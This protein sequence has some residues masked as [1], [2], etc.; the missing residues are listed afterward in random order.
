MKK[1]SL[2]WLCWLLCPA[3]ALTFHYGPGQVWLARDR[4]GEKISLANTRSVS[5]VEKQEL[6]YQSQL[7]V[8]EARKQ[9]FIEGV[10][11]QSQP[12]H[13]LAIAVSDAES[14][15]EM[16]YQ[17]AAEEWS[18]VTLAYSQASKLLIES[19]GSRLGD[20]ELV[21]FSDQDLLESLRWAEARGMVRSGLVFNGIDQFQALLDLR[22]AEFERDFETPTR[23]TNASNGWFGAE[24]RT[25]LSSDVIREELASA[26][27]VGARLLREEGRSPEL[28]RPVSNSARQHFRYLAER[29][30]AIEDRG[31]TVKGA[32]TQSPRS[33]TEV[34][35]ADRAD[36]VESELSRAERMQRNLEQV[37]NLEKSSSEQLEGIPLPRQ[38]PMARRPGDGQPGD[39]PGRGPGRGPLQDGPP[40]EGAGIPGPFGSGW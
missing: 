16:L 3:F 28:W 19:I 30:L 6:A 33:A 12:E 26:Q 17:E 29:E 7:Q 10:D 32:S 4:V 5:A 9:A 27:Y 14:R 23:T 1:K 38:A 8:I 39:R 24:E 2:L 22:G 34:A 36:S 11:W 20:G 35:M 40:G 13:P 18:K 37:L 21:A 15:Q 25:R 31:G